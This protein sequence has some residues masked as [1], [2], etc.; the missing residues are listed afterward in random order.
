MG[1]KF[2]PA[3]RYVSERP[4]AEGKLRSL[5][6]VHEVDLNQQHG[7]SVCRMRVLNLAQTCIACWTQKSRHKS[8]HK[9]DS[10]S[11]VPGFWEMQMLRVQTRRSVDTEC[12]QINELVDHESRVVL[13]VIDVSSLLHVLLHSSGCT[14]ARLHMPCYKVSGK[15]HNLMKS[16]WTFFPALFLVLRKEIASLTSKAI[17][18]SVSSRLLRRS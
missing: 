13:T 8:R 4:S 3:C 2:L 5:R 16:V 10:V 17:S 9:A 15:S 6:S 1:S 7:G 18:C 11:A 14:D 12:V